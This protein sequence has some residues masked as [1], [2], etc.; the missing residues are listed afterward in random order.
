MTT[1]TLAI[2][3]P[4][5]YQHRLEI[6]DIIKENG[7]IILHEKEILAS[8]ELASQFYKDHVGRYYFEKLINFMSSGPVIILHLAKKDAV[9]EWRKLIGPTN[10]NEA[11]EK[12]PNTIRAKFGTDGTLNAVHGSGNAE[13]AG[14]EINFFF[15]KQGN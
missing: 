1:E 9:I 10:S 6:I 15:P 4:D 14:Q 2:I 3:K 12:V 13:E 8:K 11:R 5:A 7:F